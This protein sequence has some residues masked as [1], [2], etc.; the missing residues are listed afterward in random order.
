VGETPPEGSSVAQFENWNPQDSLVASCS[1]EDLYP[2]DQI[3]ALASLCLFRC[4]HCEKG[5][6]VF[7]YS[8]LFWPGPK[9]EPPSHDG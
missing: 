6:W 7:Q 3:S 4:L 5:F 8:G 9:T 2:L 1:L